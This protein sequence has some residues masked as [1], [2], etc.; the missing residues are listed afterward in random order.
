M[1]PEVWEDLRRLVVDDPALRSRLLGSRDRQAF[2][3][4]LIE[5]AHRRG[6][7]LSAE[8]ILEALRAEQRRR[9]ERWV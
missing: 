5:I 2:A 1:Q 8:E 6:I 3:V 7:E 4:T 9:R